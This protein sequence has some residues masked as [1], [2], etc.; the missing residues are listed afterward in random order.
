MS[1]HSQRVFG[2]ACILV[3]VTPAARAEDRDRPSGAG[4]A[5]AVGLAWAELPAPAWVRQLLRPRPAPVPWGRVVRTGLAVVGPVAVGMATGHL[6]PGLI[7]SMG[8]LAA[9][10][11]DRGGPYRQRAIRVG[12][13]VAAG[14]TGFL[15]GSL[16]FGH[17]G[18]TLVLVVGAALVSGLVSVLGNTASVASLQFVIYTVVASGISFGDGPLW[19]APLLYLLGAAWELVLSLSTG[20]GRTAAPERAAVAA[21]YRSLAR[22]L[23]AVGGDTVEQERQGLTDALNTAYDAVVTAR[24][25]SGGHDD[26]YRRL[27]AV[28]NEATPLVEESLTLVRIGRPLPEPVRQAV[29]DLAAAV[30][31]RGEPPDVSRLEAPTPEI[32]ALKSGLES[33]TSL[34]AG[35]PPGDSE[36]Q[37]HRTGLRER[38]GSAWD[39]L[40]SGPTTQLTTLRLVLCMGV[41]ETVMHTLPLHRPYWVALTVAVAVKPDFGSVFARAVQRGLG[42]V[43]GVL[44]GTGLLVVLP[45]GAPILVAIAVLSALMPIALMRNYGMFATFLTPVIVL[46]IDLLHRGDESLVLARLV[47]TL[48]GS[49]IV[50]VVGYLIW[51]DTWRSRTRIGQR[52]AEVADDVLA[53]LRVAIGP[54]HGA[55]SPL[56]RHTYR[57]LSDLRTMFQQALSEPPPVSTRASAWW[58]AIVA[59]E[60]LTDAVTATVIHAQHGGP[61]PSQ[62][63]AALVIAAME[64]LPAAVREQRAPED[65]PLP[66]EEPLAGV[67]AELKVVRG[68]LSGP[69]DRPVPSHRAGRAD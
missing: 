67:V 40:S 23:E 33:V 29:R 55:R 25:R 13:V 43:I 11:T 19:Q 9:S 32:K 41:A 24:S 64:D 27:L 20:I 42:T 1:A 4:P 50:L 58:P 3:D 56:R 12:T 36:Q 15:L 47:D 31:R 51:P 35:R 28:L 10:L 7:G 38:L 34:L 22:L 61:A 57:R 63:G 16:A 37:L 17:A 30:A 46:L 54:D 2:K 69:S 14:A 45:Y 68:V 18:W 44:I 53:Y 26:Q 5:S 6:G 62:D 65:R 59:L 66:E 8:A 60:R 52:F 39:A 48:L 21:V 49:A